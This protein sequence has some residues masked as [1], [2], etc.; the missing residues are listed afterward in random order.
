MVSNFFSSGYE[1]NPMDF[2]DWISLPETELF[3]AIPK[4]AKS[5]RW[6]NACI[7]YGLV[8]YVNRVNVVRVE[9]TL[10]KLTGK[11]QKLFWEENLSL[12]PEIVIARVYELSRE[13]MAALENELRKPVRENLATEKVLKKYFDELGLCFTS[14]RVTTGGLQEVFYL[15]LR[16]RQR[17]RQLK[18]FTDFE[19][20]NIKNAISVFSTEL[21]IID[22]LNP[23]E[24]IFYKGVMAAGIVM[25]T[26]QQP[27][28]RVKEFLHLLNQEQGRQENDRSDP[29]DILLRSI[30]RHRV[31]NTLSSPHTTIG[32][33]LKTLEAITLWQ[34]GE[35]SPQ[36]WRRK[37]LEGIDCVPLIE[38]LRAIK[39]IQNA[40]DL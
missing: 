20:I 25:L 29:V 18:Q 1:E 8:D 17:Y 34:A 14:K 35:D 5:E 15:A 11:E 33:F 36:F 28:N 39:S 40:K 12:T 24:N 37:V 2:K 16:G 31:S 10:Y 6:I 9:G 19:E 22:D 32:L 4:L 21:K 38:K 13:N 3:E 7:R 30:Y 23:K 26:I 27:N